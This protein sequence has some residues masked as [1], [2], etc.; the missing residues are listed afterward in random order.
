MEP[1]VKPRPEVVFGFTRAVKA[2]EGT[3]NVTINSDADGPLEVFVNVGR[4]GNDIA[5]MAEAI[6]R[7]ISLTLRLP[8]PM[9]SIARM[10]HIAAQLRHIG[11]SRAVGFGPDQVRSLPDAVAKALEE[12][13]AEVSSGGGSLA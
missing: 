5:A 13:I 6:G 1:D 10:A 11:G 3:V 7:L 4:A 2:P 12:H 8:S 9:P